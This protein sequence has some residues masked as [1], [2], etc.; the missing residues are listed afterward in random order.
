MKN[1]RKNITNLPIVLLVFVIPIFLIFSCGEDPI[2]NNPI[3]DPSKISPTIT[4]T[5]LIEE[6]GKSYS[7]TAEA[8]LFSA[9]HPL[10]TCTIEDGGVSVN[11]IEM[12]ILYDLFGAPYYKASGYLEL[13]LGDTTTVTVT[14]S[15][16]NY[17]DSTV[18]IQEKDLDSLNFQS[19]HPHDQD[20]PISWHEVDTLNSMEIVI[21]YQFGDS[22][23]VYSIEIPDS[24]L[25][26]GTY[27]ISSSY[28]VNLSGATVQITIQSIKD[29]IA[30]SGFHNG[31]IQSVLSITKPCVI[32]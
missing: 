16:G 26:V 5:R 11:G 3:T 20:L 10:Q 4:V 13:D 19:P 2:S 12:D 15:D 30:N 21:D 29:G 32:E 31:L 17:Y 25:S 1:T 7:Q 23:G 8:W 18:K 27:S 22:T 28:F 24:C 6:S 14:L 9:A